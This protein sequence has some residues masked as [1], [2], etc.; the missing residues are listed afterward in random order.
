MKCFLCAQMARASEGKKDSSVG[1]F[2][3]EMLTFQ[4]FMIFKREK[5]MQDYL[6]GTF[7]PC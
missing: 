1:F 2:Q 5:E 7:H 6:F 4:V 3:T